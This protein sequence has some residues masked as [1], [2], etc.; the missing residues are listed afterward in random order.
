LSA[1]RLRSREN[2]RCDPG[3]KKHLPEKGM[4]FIVNMEIIIGIRQ[5]SNGKMTKK[6]LP[7]V[8]LA[9]LAPL[10]WG[11]T[12]STTPNVSRRDN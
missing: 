11:R 4:E 9:V 12:S 7:R 10:A 1:G 3:V 2:E 6:T 8:A 5:I